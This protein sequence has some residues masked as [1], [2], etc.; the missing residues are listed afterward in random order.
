MSLAPTAVVSRRMS[1][2]WE[3]VALHDERT[4][5]ARIDPPHRLQ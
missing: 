3:P 2:A 1:S 4:V 5:L